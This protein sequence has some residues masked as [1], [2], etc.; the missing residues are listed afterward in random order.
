MKHALCTI[1]LVLKAYF[2]GTMVPWG[3]LQ[4]VVTTEVLQLSA[5]PFP[6]KYYSANIKL[7]RGRSSSL[8]D[9]LRQLYQPIA[10]PRLFCF[11]Y[12]LLLGLNGQKSVNVY[13]YIFAKSAFVWHCVRWKGM[14]DTVLHPLINLTRHWDGAEME[15]PPI[16]SVVDGACVNLVYQCVLIWLSVLYMWSGGVCPLSNAR[17]HLHKWD[18]PP[19]YNVCLPLLWLM[20]FPGYNKLYFLLHFLLCCSSYSAMSN[21]HWCVTVVKGTLVSAD[22]YDS[23]LIL[24]NI[25]HIMHTFSCFYNMYCVFFV[26]CTPENIV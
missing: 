7:T 10:I 22:L 25:Q 1:F 21:L 23:F 2:Y 4:C 26:V 5:S 13:E 16:D 19:K 11:L 17:R 14:P 9:L 12:S 3:F 15:Y 20:I 6:W 24:G 18:P 8:H